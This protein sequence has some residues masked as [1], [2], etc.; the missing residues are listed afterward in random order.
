MADERESFGGGKDAGGFDG[1]AS[2]GGFRVVQSSTKDLDRSG[3]GGGV[4]GESANGER[5]D[6]RG[7]VSEGGSVRFGGGLSL[8]NL[9]GFGGGEFGLAC[10]EVE[11]ESFLAKSDAL[12]ELAKALL[13]GFLSLLKFSFL[14]KLAGLLG[15]ATIGPGAGRDREGNKDGGKNP[16]HTMEINQKIKIR[17]AG[18]SWK[19]DFNDLFSRF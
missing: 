6:G 15:E 12:G 4:E 10:E 1:F 7:G 14:E 9:A 8:Q 17:K 16:R 2:N 13:K 11:V 19:F 3:M 18:W 5:S